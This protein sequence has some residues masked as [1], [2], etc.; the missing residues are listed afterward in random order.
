V[1]HAVGCHCTEECHLKTRAYYNKRARTNRAKRMAVLVEFRLKKGCID[2]GYNEHPAALQFDHVRGTKRANVSA[3]AA[4]SWKA[5][6]EEVRKCEVRC[7]N[8][9]A[10]KT[11]ESGALQRGRR[12][13]PPKN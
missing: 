8:C 12:A 3:L 5:V 7:A 2:C 11:Y 10:I 4:K 1:T 13:I 6:I 9:H